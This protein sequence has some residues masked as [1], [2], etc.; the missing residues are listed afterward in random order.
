M[1][2]YYKM[3]CANFFNITIS[4]V[5]EKDIIMLLEFINFLAS[6]IYNQRTHLI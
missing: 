3:Q 4:C 5:K 2:H 6:L 1:Q